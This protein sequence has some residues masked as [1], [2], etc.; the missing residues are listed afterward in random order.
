MFALRTLYLA[1]LLLCLLLAD[2]GH[3]NEGLAQIVQLVLERGDGG[4]VLD[5]QFF[6]LLVFSEYFLDVILQVLDV[7]LVLFGLDFA[8]FFVFLL[9]LLLQRLHM[10]FMGTGGNFLLQFVL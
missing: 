10:G 3:L 6:V 5:E 9:F 4:L 7:N 8:L 1:P 2:L